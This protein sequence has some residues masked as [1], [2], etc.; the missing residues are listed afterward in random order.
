MS[1]ADL[2]KKISPATAAPTLS[3]ASAIRTAKREFRRIDF[4]MLATGL[5]VFAIKVFGDYFDSE[6][7]EFASNLVV[8]TLVCE[9][10]MI[11]LA[12]GAM[13]AIGKP[14][15]LRI[16]ILIV[17]V[18]LY[19]FAVTHDRQFSF[20]PQALWLLFIRLVPPG[21]VG[22]FSNDN[23]RRVK[24]IAFAGL[25]CLVLQIVIFAMASSALSALGV[26]TVS[27][28]TITMPAWFT[29]VVWGA[30]Y[31]ELAFVIPYIERNLDQ[32]A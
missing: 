7:R 23:V 19:T 26:G 4:L 32:F 16:L 24:A 17:T 21:F 13:V 2:E 25:A 1:F 29:G 6:M 18:A 12:M 28:N 10:Y 8:R 30:Y 20:A 14:T 27:G 31:I 3:A 9:G 22:V 5:L 15:W 11:F